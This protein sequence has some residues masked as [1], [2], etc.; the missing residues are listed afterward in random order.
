MAELVRDAVV[1]AM[2]QATDDNMNAVAWVGIYGPEHAAEPDLG[3]AKLVVGIRSL[4]GPN[5]HRRQLS[6][7]EHLEVIGKGVRALEPAG[8]LAGVVQFRDIRV[9]LVEGDELDR[10]TIV[11][12][13]LITA[14]LF[15]G[16]EVQNG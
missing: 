16:V 10:H 13:G 3:A 1:R 9:E 11:K 5:R 15:E 14:I 7:Q 2:V 6:Y 8:K 4:D 12:P